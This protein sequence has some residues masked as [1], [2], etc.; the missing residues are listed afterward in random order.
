MNIK[1]TATGNSVS[2]FI[3][4]QIKLPRLYGYLSFFAT[5]DINTELVLLPRETKYNTLLKQELRSLQI[6]YGSNSHSELIVCP[7]VTPCSLEGNCQ[8]CMGTTFFHVWSECSEVT[9]IIS[10]FILYRMIHKCSQS[11]VTG[12]CV[13]PGTSSPNCRTMFL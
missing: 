5:H 1:L 6:Y 9:E 13:Q 12:P 8:N 3:I 2:Y 4:A 10:H 11:S 7:Y